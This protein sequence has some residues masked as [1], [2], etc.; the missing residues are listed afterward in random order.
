MIRFLAL[1]RSALDR[2]V[3]IVGVALYAGMFVL[4]IL[5]VTARYVFGTPLAW[6]DELCIVLML[7]MLFWTAAFVLPRDKQVSL[8]IIFNAAPQP[9]QRGMALLAAWG[10]GL[11]FAA[12]AYPTYDYI[13]FLWRER[14]SALEWSLDRVYF[15]FVIFIVATAVSL[16]YRGVRLGGRDWP[17]WL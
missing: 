4:F 6:S 11:I 1:L 17:R 9:A 3:E 16:L 5:G 14:T 12:A 13:T 15:C 10:F 7:W 8:D 2:A